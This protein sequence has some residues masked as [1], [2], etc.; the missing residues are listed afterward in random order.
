MSVLNFGVMDYLPVPD[1]RNMIDVESDPVTDDIYALCEVSHTLVKIDAKRNKETQSV[2]LPGLDVYDFAFDPK[3]RK[4]LVTDYLTTN[5]TVVDPDAMKVVR[6]IRVGWVSTGVKYF[7]DKFYVALPLVSQV[8]EVD[9]DTYEVT[10]KLD[11]GYG[12]RDIEIDKNRRILFSGNY[13][14]GSVDAVDLNTGK[15][16]KRAKAGGLIRGVEYHAKTD[17][18]YIASGCGVKFIPVGKWLNE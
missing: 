11:V 13:L 5:A 9:A 16:L 10:R 15:R 1:C 17:R 7:D 6:K 3:R 8:V 18:L 2:K 4:F 14:S 12:V